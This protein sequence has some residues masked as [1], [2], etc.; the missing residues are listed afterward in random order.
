MSY[1][2]ILH[3]TDFSLASEQAFVHALRMALASKGQLDILHVDGPDEQPSPWEVYPQVRESLI[4]WSLLP[5]NATREDVAGQLGVKVSKYRPR[6]ADRVKEIAKAAEEL[7]A[8]LIVLASHCR[9]GFSRLVSKNVA[10]PLLR[11][12]K[13]PTLVLPHER[14]G[15][16]AERDG[17]AALQRILLPVDEGAHGARALAAAEQLVETLGVQSGAAEWL[18]VGRP[19][20]LPKRP[21]RL[22]EWSWDERAEEGDVVETILRR[23]REGQAA[24]IV[25]A[26]DG[27]DSVRDALFGSTAEQVL[28]QAPCAVLAVPTQ[29]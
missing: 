17:S 14:P 20:D 1:A 9:G 12:A 8:D 28:R 5:P 11:E 10:E 21:E 25:M 6:A 27:H 23:A 7:D 15:F 24:L 13:L 3:P 2:T 19:G 29:R 26:T 4:R 16:V 22:G 18:H